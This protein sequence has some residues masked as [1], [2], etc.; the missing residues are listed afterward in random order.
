[1]K[2]SDQLDLSRPF[3]AVFS[4]DVT[5]TLGFGSTKRRQKGKQYWYARRTASGEVYI[6]TLSDQYLPVGDKVAISLEKLQLRYTHEPSIQV[7]SRDAEL[8]EA[9]RLGDGHRG[10]Q[11]YYSAELE[12][13]RALAIDE[14][15]IRANFG[16]GLTFLKRGEA[17]K[18]R[19][20]FRKLVSLE[21]S[22][23]PEHKHLFNEFGISLRKG[24]LVEEAV[25]YYVRALQLAVEDENLHFNI[26]RACFDAGKL[27]EAHGFA[28][29]ALE[30]RPDFPE[31][32]GL[33]RAI[34]RADPALAALGVELSEVDIAD[35]AA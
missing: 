23:A 6:Q 26:A 25:R 31:A 5:H 8:D 28:V 27:K 11:E 7:V 1:V 4:E 17:D 18:A 2:D 22:F 35:G 9:V 19:S 13:Q 33:L 15:E 10:R 24:G 3:E 12:Y 29:Q 21:A 20:S 34:L 16:L 14:D 30:L 32:R